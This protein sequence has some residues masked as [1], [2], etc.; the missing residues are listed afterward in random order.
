MFDFYVLNHWTLWSVTFVTILQRTTVVSLDVSCHSPLSLRSLILAVLL[1]LLQFNKH[2]LSIHCTFYT[3][4][5]FIALQ[6]PIA[7]QELNSTDVIAS[8]DRS[9][10]E[11]VIFWTFFKD[12][13]LWGSFFCW[14]MEWTK[15]W[16]WRI[17]V[18]F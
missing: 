9:M 4:D 5:L 13:L 18:S 2:L 3:I 17:V 12:L 8:I 14:M 15:G 6:K 7:C 10:F 1:L 16:D 11:R